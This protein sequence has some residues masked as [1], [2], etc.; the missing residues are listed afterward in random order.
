MP[1]EVWMRSR[2]MR[3]QQEALDDYQRWLIEEAACAKCGKRYRDR[4]RNKHGEALDTW[5]T[6]TDC[7]CAATALDVEW[8]NEYVD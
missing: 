2:W 8:K 3:Q 5:K 6:E 1:N 4:P 7:G